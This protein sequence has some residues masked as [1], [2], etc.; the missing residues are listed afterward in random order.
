MRRTIIAFLLVCGL[1]LAGGNSLPAQE[2]Q[3][4]LWDGNH[5]LQ[6]SYDAKVGF[7]K[8]MG[9]LA[10]YEVALGGS[11]RRACLS[12]ALVSDLKGQTIDQMIKEVDKHYQDNPTK[13]ST[14]V[15]EVI[16]RRCTKLCPPETAGGEKK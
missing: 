9:N 15:I 2:Q 3:P 16:M 12:R 11:D 8:G 6:L 4:F 10:D 5:W 14:S 1:A 7:L 13:L